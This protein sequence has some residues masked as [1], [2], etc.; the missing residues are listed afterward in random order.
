M[1]DL[2]ELAEIVIKSLEG[3]LH[4]DSIVKSLMLSP[5]E[6]A[7]IEDAYPEIKKLKR[8]GQLNDYLEMYE[9][10]RMGAAPAAMYV[11]RSKTVWRKFYP[12]EE[13]TSDEDKIRESATAIIDVITK[14]SQP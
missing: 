1:E 6:L 4:I 5:D 13:D 8:T 11:H 10:T 2:R 3:G 14:R 7:T 9:L 12:Q